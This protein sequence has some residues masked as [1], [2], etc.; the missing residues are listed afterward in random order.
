[1]ETYLSDRQ[2]YE[3]EV[4][5]SK[6]W[7]EIVN[8]RQHNKLRYRIAEEKSVDLL[9]KWANYSTALTLWV[10]L[11]FKPTTR[12][13]FRLNSPTGSGLIGQQYVEEPAYTTFLKKLL[14]FYNTAIMTTSTGI[15]VPEVGTLH[16]RRHAHALV[17]VQKRQMH[18]FGQLLDKWEMYN[19][20]YK[21]ESIFSDTIADR[22]VRYCSKYLYKAYTSDMEN[23]F[24][25]IPPIYEW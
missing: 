13:M 17:K 3:H 12:K 22:T 18:P 14:L 24:G 9:T 2:R 8:H 4:K 10:T 15:M 6:A 16:G 5:A 23:D 1:M 20:F 25:G 19:G 11:T 7:K 21:S